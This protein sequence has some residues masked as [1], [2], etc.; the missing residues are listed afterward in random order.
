MSGAVGGRGT[1]HHHKGRG[2]L[3]VEDPYARLPRS[4]SFALNRYQ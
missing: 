4:V 1:A 2:E 3:T